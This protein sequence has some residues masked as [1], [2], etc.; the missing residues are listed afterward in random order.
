MYHEW[1]DK[2]LL[3]ILGSLKYEALMFINMLIWKWYAV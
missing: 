2:T 1:I 3:K